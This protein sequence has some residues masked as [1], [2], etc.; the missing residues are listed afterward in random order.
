[1]SRLCIVL[2]LVISYG[3]FGQKGAV[4]GRLIDY[5]S[6][7]PVADAPVI[8]YGTSMGIISNGD[9]KFSPY[10]P[11]DGEER[12]T[13]GKICVL[14]FDTSSENCRDQNSRK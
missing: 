1:M 13:D 3:S 10:K 11:V 7:K 8:L 5:N 14:D 2:F 12:Y 6:G 4:K 9:G